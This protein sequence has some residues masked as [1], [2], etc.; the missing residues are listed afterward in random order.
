MATLENRVSDTLISGTA[1]SDSIFNRGT[2]VTISVGAGSDIA[3]ILITTKKTA[4]RILQST[5]ATAMI[6]FATVVQTSQLLAARTMIKFLMRAVP[7]FST[8][9]AT[10]T[11]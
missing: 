9:K 5:Q 8:P 4:A 3:I 7:S 6:T 11:I 1:D 2:S 10:A